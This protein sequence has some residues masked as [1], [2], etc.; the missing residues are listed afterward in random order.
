[1]YTE[2]TSP[3]EEA[4]AWCSTIKS[5]A[6]SQTVYEQFRTEMALG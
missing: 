6:A 4:K 3:N 5:S 1:M 2:Q